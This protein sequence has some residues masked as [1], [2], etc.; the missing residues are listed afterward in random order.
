MVELGE[1]PLGGPGAGLGRVFSARAGSYAAEFSELG[2]A[3]LSYRAPAG[4]GTMRE[5]LVAPHDER[6]YAANAAFFGATVGRYA[7]R[8]AAAAFSLGGRRYGLDANDGANHLHGGA[9]GLSWRLWAGRAWSSGA[10]AGA[11]F[12]YLSPDGEGGY[13]GS[14]A[15]VVRYTLNEDGFL[16]IDYRADADRETPLS[17]TGHAYFNLDGGETVAGHRLALRSASYLELDEALVPTGRRVALAGG[18]DDFRT[19]TSL[20]PALRLLGGID[21]YYELDENVAGAWRDRDGLRQLAALSSASSG[22]R[23]MVYSDLPGAQLYTGKFLQGAIIRDARPRDLRPEQVGAPRSAQAFA[24]L[25]VEPSLYPDGPNR[26]E[27]P[28]CLFGPARPYRH[29]IAYRAEPASS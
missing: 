26:P 19:P 2:A 24:G 5:L 23:L 14:V 10:A 17:L 6:D 16:R 27:F 28:A 9:M 4:D 7:N 22:L 1:R 13:P 15:F 12:S 18:P 11:E 25:C 3:L 29:A 20:E 21:R 8:I